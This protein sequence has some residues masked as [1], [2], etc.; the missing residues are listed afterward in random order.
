MKERPPVAQYC[1]ICHTGEPGTSRHPVLG[2]YVCSGCERRK[3]YSL[4]NRLA[5]GQ[6][7]RLP[8]FSLEFE[9]AASR[10]D[11]EVN[12]ALILLKYGFVRTSDAT[13][14]DEY[15]SPI[16]GSLRVF[17]K[18][19]NVLN[20]LRHLVT[21]RCGTHLH[22]GFP[23]WSALYPVREEIFGPFIDHLQH[24]E[25]QTINFWGRTF[26]QQA[27]AE[28]IEGERHVCINI[29][30]RHP[31][32]E[33]RLPRFRSAQQYLAVVQFCR[34]ATAFLGEQFDPDNEGAL[35]CEQIAD[36]LLRLYRKAVGRWEAEAPPTSLTILA[37]R[38]ESLCAD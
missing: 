2:G 20:T 18:P 13:V 3:G 21:E 9:V 5:L 24:H 14:D 32:I 4:P 1:M 37:E 11:D 36:R 16:Y 33:F 10:Y 34:T 35:T 26:S 22:V 6:M 29:G 27:S 19:L 30:S 15:K 31:T 8:S 12:Q 28:L 7:G 25:E 17:R 23:D 38:R